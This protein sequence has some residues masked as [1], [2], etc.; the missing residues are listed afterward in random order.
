MARWEDAY[1]A[2]E[3]SGITGTRTK[4]GLEV[5]STLDEY[6][7]PDLDIE[8]STERNNNQVLLKHQRNYYSGTEQSSDTVVLAVSQVCVWKINNS[9]FSSI[10]DFS[11]PREEL[12]FSLGDH[13]IAA[14]AGEEIVGILL[15]KLLVDA[16]VVLQDHRA[17]KIPRLATIFA[18]SIARVQQDVNDYVQVLG[19]SD[20]TLERQFLQDIE[21][22]REEVSMIQTVLIQQEGIWKEFAYRYW[23]HYWKGGYEGKFEPNWEDDWNAAGKD[24]GPDVKIHQ[25]QEK[26]KVIRRPQEYF[27]S[28]RTQLNKLDHD[29][30][31]VQRSIELKLDL[32]QRH[33][34]LTEARKASVM[35]ALV[36]GFTIVTIVFTPLSFMTGLFALPIDR[37]QMNQVSTQDSQPGETGAYSTTYIGEWMGMSP[38][39]CRCPLTNADLV[40]LW[41]SLFP[42]L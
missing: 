15:S 10:M 1:A 12:C 13:M 16:D 37:L 4:S 35:G 8:A 36:L 3:S 21:D 14:G 17:F 22:I 38:L 40:Q 2:R 6:F 39:I 28:I 11:K 30:E 34:S 42:W 5:F 26:W 19:A 29:G 23:P 25:F 24:H 31:R 18:R 32:N 33:E 9:T 20:I 27:S 41:E 7:Y